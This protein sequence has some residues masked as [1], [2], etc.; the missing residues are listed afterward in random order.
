MYLTQQSNRAKTRFYAAICQPSLF[1]AVVGI[2]PIIEHTITFVHGSLPA[3][4]SAR[5]KDIWPNLTEATKYFRSRGFYQRWDRRALDLHLVRLLYSTLTG[6]QYGLRELPTKAYPDDRGVTLTTPRHQE[7]YTFS[8][9]KPNPYGSGLQFFRDEPKRVFD[10]LGEVKCPVLYVFG[11][12]S[13]VSAFDSMRRKKERTGK[14]DAEMIIIKE[15]GHLVPQ[16]EVDKSGVTY[17]HS[18]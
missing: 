9:A 13:E 12:K 11:G 4:A 8:K 17:L 1:T 6:Q 5:R 16:E 7:V 3:A 14:G 18:S 10:S 15:A 2:D